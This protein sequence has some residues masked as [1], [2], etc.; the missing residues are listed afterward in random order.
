MLSPR[1]RVAAGMLALLMGCCAAAQQPLVS[2]YQ[3]PLDGLYLH[4]KYVIGLGGGLTATYK[5]HVFLKDGTV[6]DDLS[7]YPR[8]SAELAE[9]RRRDPRA[10]GRWTRSGPTISI[11][12]DDPKRKPET[13]EKWTDTRPGPAG[14]GLKGRYQSLSGGGNTA[15]GGD[16]MIAAWSHYEF[17]P[18][19]T[20]TSGGGGGG[21]SG[22]GGTGV[23]VVTSGRRAEQRG[24]YRIDG[25]SLE[26]EFSD[27]KNERRWFY[28]YPD[29]DRVIG[30]GNG[31]YLV[32]K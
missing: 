12:W 14:F 24:R 28:L 31:T 15:L 4:L 29:S 21:S 19:G 7:F 8:S 11:R 22:G 1:R 13:W 18:D 3:P 6:T 20:V 2:S 26:L 32:R 17:S 16:V 30:I 10:W 25:Y 27:G 5:A 23:S 9:W